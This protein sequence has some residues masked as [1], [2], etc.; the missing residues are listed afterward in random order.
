[1]AS[2]FPVSPLGDFALIQQKLK[3]CIY[4]FIPEANEAGRYKSAPASAEH[5]AFECTTTTID[6]Y[7][8]TPRNNH[9]KVAL[10]MS[11]VSYVSCAS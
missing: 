8:L 2:Q 5:K 9:G 11:F 3:S 7:Y 6:G 1:M 4:T 10:S